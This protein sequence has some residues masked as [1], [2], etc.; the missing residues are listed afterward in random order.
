MDTTWRKGRLTN[1]P[2][3]G[4]DPRGAILPLI[5]CMRAV[6]RDFARDPG[7]ADA[8]VRDA[9]VRALAEWEGVGPGD[10]PRS[11]LLDILRERAGAS[12][13]AERT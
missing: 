12:V 7:A 3:P 4:A 1:A 9:L 2:G 6:A 10:D 13:G 8:L 11:W 5:P